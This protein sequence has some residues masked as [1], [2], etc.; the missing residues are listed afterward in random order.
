MSLRKLFAALLLVAAC[1]GPQ[2]AQAQTYAYQAAPYSW[3]AVTGAATKTAWN[4]TCTSY[5]NSPVSPF[6]PGDD[7][8][9]VVAFPSG[10]TFSFAGTAYGSV[11]ILSNGIIQFGPDAGFHRDYTPQ[12]LPI[13]AAPGAYGG[14]CANAVPTQLMPVYWR[15]IDTG[16]DASSGVYYELKG[17]APNRRFVITWSNVYLYNTNTFYNFQVILNE[18]GTFKYQYGSGSSDG[19]GATVGVQVSTTDYTQYAYNQSFIDTTNG[20]A[21][22]WYPASVSPAEIGEYRLDEATAWG[23]TPVPG[24]TVLDSSGTNHPGARVAVGTTYPARLNTARVCAG[25]SIPSNTS[26]TLISAIDIGQGPATIGAKG[27][28]SFWYR[29]TNAWRDGVSRTLFDATTIAARPFH[30]TKISTATNNSSLL[31]ALTDSANTVRTLSTGNRTVAANTWVHVGIS[32]YLAT[33]T[34]Q[35]VMQIFINGQQ[36]NF[37]R[38]T[39]SGAINGGLGTLYFGDN[40][41]SGVTPA[42]GTA[43]SAYGDLDEIRVYPFDISAP[44]AT[45]DMNITRS[46]CAVIDHYSI[47]HSGTAVTCQPEN[48]TITAHDLSH[49]AMTLTG[50]TMTLAT[51]TSH[52]TWS[53]VSAAGTLTN[54]GGGNATYV[55]SGESSIILGLADTVAET[56]NI[57]L[58]SGGYTENSGTSAPGHDPNLTFSDAGFIFATAAGAEVTIPTQVA[59]QS[60]ATYYLRGVKT[61]RTTMACQAALQGTTAINLAYQ[62]IDPSTCAGSGYPVTV[63]AAETRSIAGNNAGSWANTTAV[64]MTFNASG[65]APLTLSHADVG[66]IQLRAAATLT[67]VSVSGTSNQ[68]V[69]KPY[70]L[71]LSAITGN[72]GAGAVGGGVFTSAGTSF[73]VT[74]TAQAV[75]GTATPSYGH[76]ATPE[77]AALTSALVLPTAAS[78]GAN[79]AA[80]VSFGSFTNGVATGTASWDEVGIITLTPHIGDGDY[81]GAGDLGSGDGSALTASGNVGRFTPDHFDLAAPAITNRADINAGAGCAPASTFTYMGEPAGVS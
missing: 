35:S 4:T 43:N 13:T 9:A 71:A 23:A 21:I 77:T 73:P 39:S 6:R 46:V 18:D 49:N 78:G 53:K 56:L 40:R 63:V 24:E 47:S 36:A 3:D 64:N 12:A 58:A 33:G 32:W 16:R 60:S 48:I 74:V 29:S 34:N 22:L 2:M 80:T 10:F 38:F 41:T 25:A 70:S 11:R 14:G 65:Y 54:T 69:V 1:V 72:P 31:F 67:G 59:G 27:S 55:W 79:P 28:V 26:N 30:L 66:M 7:V 62:C 8:F 81:L 20:T 68:F 44:Q 15:D 50:T 76:E 51:S 42:S 17:T 57:N 19:T 5:P 75:G 45:G 37:V 52:G 61:D